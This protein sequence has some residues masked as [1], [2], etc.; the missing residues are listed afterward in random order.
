MLYFEGSQIPTR[1]AT[2]VGSRK[3]PELVV[4]LHR[5]AFTGAAENVP[6]RLTRSATISSINSCLSDGTISCI[7][8]HSERSRERIIDTVTS[9]TSSNVR[10]YPAPTPEASQDLEQEE[11]RQR[12]GLPADVPVVLFF[13]ELRHEKGPDILYEAVDGFDRPL[14]VVYAG[15]E[16]DYSTSDVSAWSDAVDD[17][18]EILNRV[19]YVPEEKV[20]DY[21]VASDA[22]VV[23]YR[24]TR[25]IS[26]P[27]RRAC[28]TNRHVIGPND[29]DVGDI[30][31]RHHL[32]QTFERE[33]PAALQETL[34]E[35]LDNRDRYPLDGVSE[36]GEQLHW[37]ET[38]RT[39]QEIYRS[40]LEHSA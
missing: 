34:A 18:V 22:L 23:P 28:M 5:D 8:V 17:P 40:S 6:S 26:G 1:L 9:A 33:S 38:G 27:L 31:E 20:N 16:Y 37:H 2:A 3:L 4:T 14:A 15:P 25:G 10:T 7:T 24:R 32:G 19:E 11:V 39:L 35:F 29:S 36:Y 12:L 21:F 30:I 13:G